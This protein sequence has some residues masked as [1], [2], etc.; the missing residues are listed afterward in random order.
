M[1]LCAFDEAIVKLDKHKTWFSPENNS[2]ISRE[3]PY[4]K[5]YTIL[6]RYEP[7]LNNTIYFIATLDSSD[8]AKT[9]FTTRRDYYGR[10]Y[11]KLTSDIIQNLG[12]CYITNST[13]IDVSLVEHNIDGDI[14][15]IDV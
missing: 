10:I 4:R 6:K 2:I 9:I 12:L 11:F 8:D 15:K 5:Y 14:Y 1:N 3:I 7:L 13:N